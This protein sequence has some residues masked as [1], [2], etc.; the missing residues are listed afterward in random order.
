M[1]RAATSIIANIA[2]GYR[3]K[4][5]GD[6]IHYVSTAIGSSNELSVY[7]ILSRDLKHLNNGEFNKLQSSHDEILKIL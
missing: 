5:L 7:L 3:K 2:E 6:Y 1:R 4:S